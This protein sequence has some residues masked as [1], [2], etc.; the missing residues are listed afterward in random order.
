[1]KDGFVK[2]GSPFGFGALLLDSNDNNPIKR[3]INA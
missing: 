2:N 1:M 3:M